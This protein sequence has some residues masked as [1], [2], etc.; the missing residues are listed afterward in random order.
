VTEALR[1]AYIMSWLAISKSSNDSLHLHLLLDR[2]CMTISLQEQPC[3]RRKLRLVAD[4]GMHLIL[5]HAV[6]HAAERLGLRYVRSD[7]SPRGDM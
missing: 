5:A 7:T 6:R 2:A 3:R 4:P 1:F